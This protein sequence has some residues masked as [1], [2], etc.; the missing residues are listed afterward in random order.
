[1]RPTLAELHSDCRGHV[2][3]LAFLAG[4]P[5]VLLI[6]FVLNTGEHLQRRT[7]L[8]NAAD[9]YALTQ[10]NWTARS[11]NVMAM[12]QVAMTQ[13]LAV[14]AG[15]EALQAVLIQALP[16]AI[17]VERELLLA[18]RV[19]CNPATLFTGCLLYA[20]AV[21]FGAYVIIPWTLIQV[22]LAR[23][24]VILNF[25]R[26]AHGFS[27]M[28]DHVVRSFP[29]FMNRLQRRV[30]RENRVRLPAFYP[31]ARP[32]GKRFAS[33]PLPVRQ[34]PLRGFPDLCTAGRLGTRLRTNE[35]FASHRYGQFR[36]PAKVV[37]RSLSRRVMSRSLN[38]TK[39]GP[40]YQSSL[41]IG[42]V[43]A[44]ASIF[45]S[46][47]FGSR[48]RQ[49][50]RSNSVSRAFARIHG[51]HCLS[52]RTIQGRALHLYEPAG[53][54]LRSATK[55]QR[56]DLSLLVVTRRVSG[57]AVAGRLWRTATR[58]TSAYAQA[59]VYN[60]SRLPVPLVELA[61]N[62]DLF[63][64]GWRGRLTPSTLLAERR[65]DLVKLLRR[66]GYRDLPRVLTAL[67]RNELG[68]LNAH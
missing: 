66:R 3:P 23:S 35:N 44:P 51:A 52:R 18:A 16:N 17:K 49:S 45:P 8:Q 36:G 15:A 43:P 65:K 37:E 9:A 2:V 19:T 29:E 13:S 63:T 68:I 46:N 1:M 20:E 34:T 26:H 64:Q 6:I 4:V 30:A 22:Q 27:L 61:A 55:E 33:T 54:S 53:R 38:P 67:P 7:E 48:S 10:A 12:N 24:N 21:R 57:P 11:M 60:V 28:N 62:Y 42:P 40:L 47:K 58:E 14:A 56:R 31:S 59:E 50:L 5:L 39:A 41:R 25:S 32:E